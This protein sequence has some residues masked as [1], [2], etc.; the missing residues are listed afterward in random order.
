MGNGNLIKEMREML[1]KENKIPQ[2]QFNRLLLHAISELLEGQQAQKEAIAK[3]NTEIAIIRD[4]SI[5]L[6]IKNNRVLTSALLALIWFVAALIQSPEGKLM[7]K[8]L[9]KLF[10]NI[11][12]PP[13]LL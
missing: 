4:N 1:E 5:V 8:S 3:Q 10:F 13:E 2:A 11:N 6:W 12:I 9:L 7:F